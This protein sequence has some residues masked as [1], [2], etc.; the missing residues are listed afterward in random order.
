[1]DNRTL[2]KDVDMMKARRDNRPVIATATPLMI[3]EAPL[4]APIDAADFSRR[5]RDCVFIARRTQPDRL[6][7]AY[8]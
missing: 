1:M 8:Q 6:Y 4:F 2:L 7:N 5:A 3:Y